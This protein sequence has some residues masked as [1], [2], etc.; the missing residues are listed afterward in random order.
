MSFYAV[1]VS[2]AWFHVLVGD[3]G[4]TDAGEHGIVVRIQP[5]G[6][7]LDANRKGIACT[8]A[9]VIELRDKGGNVVSAADR[10][11]LFRACT[12]HLICMPSIY[13]LE[14]MYSDFSFGVQF[15]WC[16]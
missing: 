16:C 15:N 5:S 6:C 9:P 12:R 3:I 14:N 2:T 7:A 1:P 11:V 4:K 13:A 8:Q 10:T